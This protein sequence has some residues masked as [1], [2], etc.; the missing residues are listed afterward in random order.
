MLYT[1]LVDNITMFCGITFGLV[2]VITGLIFLL[3]PNEF[4]EY[5]QRFFKKYPKFYNHPLLFSWRVEREKRWYIVLQIR[6]VG[7]ILLLMG[8]ILS[9]ILPLTI[10]LLISLFRGRHFS[11]FG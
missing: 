3:R 6:W 7:L 9:G 2:L 4:Y 1:M 11:Y 10:G 8:L 5:V